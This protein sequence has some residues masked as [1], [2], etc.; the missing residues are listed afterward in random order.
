MKSSHH[1]SFRSVLKRMLIFATVAFTASLYF[2]LPYSTTAAAGGASSPAN[3]S[4]NAGLYR[5]LVP[6]VDLNQSRALK[7]L[8]V[9][10]GE[11]LA[12]LTNLKSS[13]NATD[14]VSRWNDFGG[15]PDVI[16]GF[17]SKPYSGNAEQAARSFI[18]DNAALFGVADASTLRLVSNRDAL[19]GHLVRFQ[20]TFNGIDVINGGVGVVLNG[21]NRV[22]MA[23]GPYF[24]N[25]TVNTQ[26]SI[27]AE[28]AKQAASAELARYHIDIPPN[29]RNLLQPALTALGEK[30]N[31]VNDLEPRLGIYPTVDGYKLVWKVS[32]FSTDPFGLFLT[33]IDAQTGQ[34]VARK[35]FIDFQTQG[36]LPYTADI[37]PKYPKIDDNL[38]NNSVISDCG[39][40]PCGQ[41][42]VNLRSFDQQNVVTGVSGALHGTH[43]VVKNVLAT[44]QPFPQAAMGTWHFRQ[45][46]APLEARTNEADQF[47]E[48][49]EHQDEINSFFFVTYL[50]EYVDYLHVAGDNP[51]FGPGAFPDTYPS[52]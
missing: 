43:A 38:K 5:R 46:N 36:V 1:H 49:A 37:Y 29:V 45:D 14:M 20:Q 15:S 48:P 22:V 12:A 9:A 18:Q 4:A 24:R 6:D 40:A 19:G 33:Q 16:Y 11:Q 31:L 42:R 28:A 30:A 52:T 32:Q 7:N 34:V 25:V 23:S 13:A 3:A 50:M 21:Q 8:R 47:A 2:Y 10:T 26:P 41:E 35:D 27:S 17:A 44:Q 51:A 39:G